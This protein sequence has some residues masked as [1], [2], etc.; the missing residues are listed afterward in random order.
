MDDFC[1]GEVEPCGKEADHAQISAL[2]EALQVPLR[3]AYL[4]RSEVGEGEGINWV[5]FGPSSDEE[6]RPLTLL[7]RPGHYDVV[8][9]DVLPSAI[10]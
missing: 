3:I 2:S 7:Y 1:R 9:K 8:S 4:D 5:Q 6:D 10:L